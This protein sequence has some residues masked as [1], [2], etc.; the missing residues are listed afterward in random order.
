MAATLEAMI[1]ERVRAVVAEELRRHGLANPQRDERLLYTVPEAAK[2]TSM[3]AEHLRRWIAEGRLTRRVKNPDSRKPAFLVS[4]DEI[5]RAAAGA[6]PVPDVPPPP[7]SLAAAR[8]ARK[9]R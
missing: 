7:V 2:L 8:I 5:R 6:I 9:A 3:S 1:D 4:L